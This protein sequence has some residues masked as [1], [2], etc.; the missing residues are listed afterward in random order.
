M[1]LSVF[2]ILIVHQSPQDLETPLHYEAQKGRA[3]CVALLLER[4]ADI[5]LINK[6]RVCLSELSVVIY[7]MHRM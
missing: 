6:V 2:T 3:D 4:G 7:M 1:S 5:Y